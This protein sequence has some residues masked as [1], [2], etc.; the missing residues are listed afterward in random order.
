MI[1]IISQPWPWYVS[2]FLIALIMLILL[3]MGKRFGMSSNL[4]TICTIC[5]GGKASDFFRFDWRKDSWNLLIVFGAALGGFIASHYLSDNTIPKVSEATIE[6]LS[7]MNFSS[8]NAYLP[9]ELFS[10]E[11]FTDFK[12]VLILI[13][14]GILVGFGARYAG[15]CTS[16]H[17]ISG[18]SNLQKGSLIAVIGFFIGGLVMIH[19]IYPLIF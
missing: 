5:G 15:G 18:L 8:E 19:L 9:K 17:A 1:E 6:A 14:G 10:L 13:I 7:E 11:A 12:T 3:L 2:G 16:G 4:K